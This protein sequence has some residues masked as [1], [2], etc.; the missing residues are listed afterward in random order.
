MSGFTP[1]FMLIYCFAL[2]RKM[3][4]WVTFCQLRSINNATESVCWFDYE[5]FWLHF[6]LNIN[7]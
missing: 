7:I 6:I 1:I 4:D 3:T 5:Q 2:F